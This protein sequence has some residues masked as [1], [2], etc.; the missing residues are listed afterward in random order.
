MNPGGWAGGWGGGPSAVEKGD[1]GFHINGVK[2]FSLKELRTA[3]PI[4]VEDARIGEGGYGWVNE[5]Y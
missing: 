1:G 3:T 2:A 4:F 5:I